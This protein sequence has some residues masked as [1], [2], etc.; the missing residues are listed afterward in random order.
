MIVT[1][2]A[3]VWWGE[4]IKRKID[5]WWGA[6][7]VEDETGYNPHCIQRGDKAVRKGVDHQSGPT[8]LSH[9]DTTKLKRRSK[10]WR[11]RRVKKI[12]K[13]MQWLLLEQ[14]KEKCRGATC[15]LPVSHAA[16]VAIGRGALRPA[17]SHLANRRPVSARYANAFRWASRVTGGLNGSGGGRGRDGKER[18]G[19][20]R[21]PTREPRLGAAAAA[22]T[23]DRFLQRRRR[24]R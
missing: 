20:R 5:G 19:R 23:T 18:E 6:K 2:Q 11:K 24:C 21:G 3:V 13:T 9:S 10:R 12:E 17:C 16:A 4:K 14:K 22:K 1:E 7:G 8:P 15:P